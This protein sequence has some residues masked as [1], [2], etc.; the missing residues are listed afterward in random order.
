[1]FLQGD[2]VVGEG[3]EVDIA[4]EGV[5]FVEEG[6]GEEEEEGR[7]TTFKEMEIGSVLILGE[8]LWVLRKSSYRG[9]G[10]SMRLWYR[11]EWERDAVDREIFFSQR[12]Y[13]RI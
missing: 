11:A 3:E 9:G 10:L 5:V 8:E 2:I 4:E 13:M 1:M 12:K 7:A 6:E